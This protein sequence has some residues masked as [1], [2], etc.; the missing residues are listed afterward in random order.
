VTLRIRRLPDVLVNKIAAG[1]VVERPAS[2]VK[3]LVENALDAEATRVTIDLRHAG[4][5]LVRVVDDGIGMTADELD[6]ALTRHATS[7][8]ASEEDLEAVRTLGFRGEAL[9]AICAV[10]RFSLASCPHGA[11]SGTLVRGEGGIVRDRLEAP[12]RTGTT[13]EVQDLFFNTPA[14]LKFLKSGRTEQ[15][16][17]MR[18][19][20]GIAL[21]HPEVHLAVTHDARPV[22]TAPR[23]GD[24]RDRAGALYGFDLAGKLLAVERRAG[25]LAV[26]GLVGAPQHARGNRDEITLVVNGRPVRDTLLTQTILDAYRPLLARDQFPVAVL[27]IDLPP[28]EVDVN[29]HPTKA[30]VRFRSPRLVQEALFL[31][32]QAALRSSEVVQRQAGLGAAAGATGLAAEPFAAYATEPGA[33]ERPQGRLFEDA[34]PDR[35]PDLFGAVVGQLQDTF[36]VSSSEEEVFFVDQHVAHERVLFERLQQDAR[37]G[38]IASQ[39]L[40]FPQA[41][42]LPRGQAS[43]LAEWRDTLASLGFVL[44]GFG[45]DA[46]LIRAVP[47]VLA[48]REPRRL[49][50]RLLD[51]VSAPLSGD[52]APLLDRALAFVA[53]RAAIKAPAPLEREEMRRLLADLSATATPYFCPHGRPIVSRLS[54]REIKRELKRTW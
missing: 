47:A 2:A 44:E 29:V 54:L 49:I 1:E 23:A 8:I 36:I 39:E 38:G 13:V 50:E 3:E 5:Q 24:L 33:G 37:Q 42:D 6:L 20:H 21:A 28:Q 31:A 30:W 4:T 15:A 46:I 48:A 45:G 43:L 34:P 25:V 10:T 17:I 32:V 26:S 27:R 22:L 12:G 41:L 18:V 51:E 53:C 19:L 11:A 7:K 52:A 16:L 35:G 9:P 14:R 40:L